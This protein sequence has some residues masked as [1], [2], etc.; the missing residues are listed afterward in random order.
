MR[1]AI[2]H[3]LGH[4]LN[5]LYTL[6]YMP[7]GLSQCTRDDN[8]QLTK[9]CG[10]EAIA[11]T[12]DGLGTEWISEN[13]KKLGLNKAE[14]TL[15]HLERQL[16]EQ[17]DIYQALYDILEMR[18]NFQKKGGEEVPVMMSKITGKAIFEADFNG[19]SGQPIMDQFDTLN[20]KL[21]LRLSRRI[22]RRCKKELGAR[23]FRRNR[24][25]ILIGLLLGGWRPDTFERFYFDEYLPR[26]QSFLK[27]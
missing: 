21:G 17:D 1:T 20:Y 18:K 8:S 11:L 12:F 24:Q 14:L 13:R 6:K 9:G 25:I 3:E 16:Y 7:R 26:V 15:M 22:I 27:P 10:S 23:R 4:A 2:L 5:A 19:L